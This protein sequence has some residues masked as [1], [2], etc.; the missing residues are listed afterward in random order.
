MFTRSSASTRLLHSN[1]PYSLRK[2]NMFGSKKGS[3]IHS[4]PLGRCD[5]K[6]RIS[7][8]TSTQTS[9]ALYNHASNR[10]FGVE[11]ERSFPRNYAVSFRILFDTMRPFPIAW[12]KHI[13][14]VV[15]WFPIA[16]PYRLSCLNQCSAK[17]LDKADHNNSRP[18]QSL[19]KQVSHPRT[20][21]VPALS[22]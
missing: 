16:E 20:R 18:V 22:S 7:F 5:K 6:I 1:R 11:I 14:T 19:C 15:Q 4:H 21:D 17:I 9:H 12:R 3:G 13:S 2:S 10:G 8:L